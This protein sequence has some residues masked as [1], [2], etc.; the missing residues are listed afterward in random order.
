M[1]PIHKDD[2]LGK[3]VEYTHEGATYDHKVI[4]ITGNILTVI[5]AVKQKRR[6]T[7]DQVIAWIHHG[8]IKEPID[9]SIRR[10][11]SETKDL[12]GI[13]VVTLRKESDVETLQ[14]TL[15]EVLEE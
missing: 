7:Q 2:L 13:T 1:M 6:I 9:W 15:M 4:R 3:Y 10:H 12:K 5:D 14:T 11:K 8:Y